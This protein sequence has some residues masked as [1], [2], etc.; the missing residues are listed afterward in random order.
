MDV[1]HFA[2]GPS[3]HDGTCNACILSAGKRAC[4]T[5]G[6]SDFADTCTPATMDGN[7]IQM[8]ILGMLVRAPGTV[9]HS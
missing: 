2:A 4:L 9:M 5:H 7:M 6:L 3:R 1:P 8:L